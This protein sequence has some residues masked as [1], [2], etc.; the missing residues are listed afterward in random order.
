MRQAVD[1]RQN[2]IVVSNTDLPGNYRL[3]AGGEDGVRLGFSVNQP[4]DTSRLE[5]ATPDE[6]AQL[7]GEIPFR[8]ARSQE[9]IVR[10]VN[11]GRVGRELYPLLMLLALLALLAEQWLANRFY[12]RGDTSGGARQTPDGGI[13]ST[14]TAKGT[15]KAASELAGAP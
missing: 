11:L 8:V 1:E 13:A 3:Q 14:A 10:D 2:A 7:F 6:L 9:E 15:G 4:P 12:R 5:R